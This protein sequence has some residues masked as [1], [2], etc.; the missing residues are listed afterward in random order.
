MKNNLEYVILKEIQAEEMETGQKPTQVWINEDEHD[1]FIAGRK[2]TNIP[3]TPNSIG[4]L[5]A[6]YGC[7][8]NIVE[9]V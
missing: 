4:T 9:K 2:W 5:G 7:K 1:S 3:G 6:L 8:V